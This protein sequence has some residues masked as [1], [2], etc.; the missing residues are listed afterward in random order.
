MSKIINISQITSQIQL[1]DGS[2][3]TNTTSSNQ[4]VIENMNSFSAV[5]SCTEDYATPSQELIQT[6]ILSNE[7]DI[8]VSNVKVTDLIGTGASFK[9]GSVY[10][11][12]T[13]DPSADPT[14]GIS[15]DD[16]IE[17]S[18][19]VEIEYTIVV[20]KEPTVDQFSTQSTITY[21]T[22]SETGMSASS[23]ELE[24]AIVNEQL[25]V[26][27]TSTLSAVIQGQTLTYQI[28]ITNKGNMTNTNVVF[29]DPIPSAVSFLKGTVLVNETPRT[30][31]DP[32]TGISLS[33]LNPGDQTIVKFDVKVN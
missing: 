3:K 17:P 8:S 28:T 20:D 26:E 30:D 2:Q 29:T 14:T 6:L 23:N 25:I 24:T 15:L 7:C 32:T 16:P 18:N 12:G 27:K 19:S 11:D 9:S 1:P 33:D 5:R 4:S 13:S 22:E 31:A 10:I 21:D